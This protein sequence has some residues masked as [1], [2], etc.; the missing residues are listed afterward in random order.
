MPWVLLIVYCL[1]IL[2]A[3]LVGGWI[4][5][6]IR[7]THQRMQIAMSL[8]AGLM[9]GVGLLHMM[10]HALMQSGNAYQLVFT[11]AL[12]GFLLMFFIERFFCYHH[13]ETPQAR[14]RHAG[15]PEDVAHHAE[16]HQ[17]TWSGAAVGLSLHTIIAGVAL[18]AS[19][20]VES[21]GEHLAAMAGFGTFLVIL[22]HKPFD[23]M[24]LGALMA[25]GGW[26]TFARHV[27]NGLF[28]LMIPVGVALFYLGVARGQ[29]HQGSTPLACALAFSAGTF[30]CISMS[31]LLPELHFH[32][33]DRGVLS[34]ALFVG[35]SVA[36]AIGW[37]ESQGGG[38]RHHGPPTPQEQKDTHQH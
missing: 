19:I 34:M 4:P 20:E 26:S 9:L 16:T 17:L 6:M 32:R 28:A 12:G 37:I 29:D 23:S 1:L 10:P 11:W 21:R 25:V 30:L 18:A 24:T 2:A 5:M 3:S 8:V 15:R 33:H 27:V 35:L 31:D 13:H 22:L 14:D 38:H 36:W 7:L